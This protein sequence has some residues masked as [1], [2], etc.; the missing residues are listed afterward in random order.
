M[1][2][3]YDSKIKDNIQPTRHTS[4]R[5]Q[6]QNF[7]H[8]AKLVCRLNRYVSIRSSLYSTTTR[9]NNTTIQRNQPV[10]GSSSRS[11][12]VPHASCLQMRFIWFLNQLMSNKSSHVCS[13]SVCSS[14]S[15]LNLS[16]LLSKT[17]VV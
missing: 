5:L 4:T 8:P 1:T 6:S 14:A 13:T 11:L 3:S 7:P 16:K 9:S 10:E 15:A 2:K 17:K 12:A